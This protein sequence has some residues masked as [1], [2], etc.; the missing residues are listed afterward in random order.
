MKS[1]NFS[2]KV[3]LT[4]HYFLN[5]TYTFHLTILY[6]TVE[7]TFLLRWVYDK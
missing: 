6:V 5:C 4:K 1:F 2:K 7:H 3:L